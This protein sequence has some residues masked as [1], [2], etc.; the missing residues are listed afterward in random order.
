MRVLKVSDGLKMAVGSG[1]YIRYPDFALGQKDYQICLRLNDEVNNELLKMLSKISRR[2]KIDDISG[3]HMKFR[4]KDNWMYFNQLSLAERFWMISY[5]AGVF[6]SNV[7]FR[8][9]FTQLKQKTLRTFFSTF[10]DNEYVTLL[11]DNDVYDTCKQMLDDSKVMV[12]FTVTDVGERCELSEKMNE[13]H[14]SSM[15]DNIR[16]V[17]LLSNMDFNIER[18][19]IVKSVLWADKVFDQDG[20][21]IIINPLNYVSRDLIDLFELVCR[22]CEYLILR[23]PDVFLNSFEREIFYNYLRGANHTYKGIYLSEYC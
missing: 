22:D 17:E 4:V 18:M 5:A 8:Y 16:D 23:E 14:R 15:V 12:N 10:K 13:L 1:S 6:K 19:N 7:V 20:H 11:V 2:Y 21:I 3:Q 9:G